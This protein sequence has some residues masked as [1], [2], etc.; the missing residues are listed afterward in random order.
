MWD[1]LLHEGAKV[2]YRVSLSLLKL[3]EAELLR[4]DNA[5]DLINHLRQCTQQLHDRD[6][7]MK[8]GLPPCAIMGPPVLW[9]C[10]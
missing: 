8:V 2:L 7:L 6:R 1:S 3:F 9:R 5:G 10:P 4:C